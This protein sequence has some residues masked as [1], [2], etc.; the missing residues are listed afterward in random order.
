MAF[1][2]IPRDVK[3]LDLFAA[4]GQNLNTAAVKLRNLVTEFDH[5]DDRIAEI[6]TLEKQGDKIDHGDQ[7]AARAGVRDALR[8][9][10]HPRPDRPD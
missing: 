3:F 9:R 2:L 6:Q 7:R 1:R 5:L 4:A 10:G 8:S